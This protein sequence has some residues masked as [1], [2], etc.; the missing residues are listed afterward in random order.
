MG[1]EGA[2]RATARPEFPRLSNDDVSRRG[3]SPETL[4]LG[5]ASKALCGAGW[6]TCGRLANRPALWGGLANLRPIG[7]SAFVG[8][9]ILAAAGCL[10]LAIRRFL[11]QETLPKGCR[12]CRPGRCD[13]P[14]LVSRQALR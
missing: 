7:K 14:P 12:S 8:Q 1:P 4:D 2:P 6:Q 5:P 13:R 9:P 10:R 3:C 11:P